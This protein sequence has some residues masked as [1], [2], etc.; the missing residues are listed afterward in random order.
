MYV[1]VASTPLAPS[2]RVVPTTRALVTIASR[3]AP[4]NHENRRD[5]SVRGPRMASFWAPA[6]VGAPL[7]TQG[8]HGF[9]EHVSDAANRANALGLTR[10]VAQLVAQVGYVHVHRAVDARVVAR[11]ALQ[12]GQ[13]RGCE[14]FAR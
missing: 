8:L 6:R 10:I 5:L 11:S 2:L 7:F 9:D 12:P 14:L 13:H 3:M 1:A 4:K